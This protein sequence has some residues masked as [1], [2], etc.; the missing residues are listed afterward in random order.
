MSNVPINAIYDPVIL[1]WHPM[2]TTEPQ[3]RN[4]EAAGLIQLGRQA[5]RFGAST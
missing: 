5:K 4:H 2:V 3:P 1:E